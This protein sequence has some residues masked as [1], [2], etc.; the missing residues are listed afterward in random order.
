MAS[1]RRAPRTGASETRKKRPTGGRSRAQKR[2]P[3]ALKHAEAQAGA[4]ADAL[5]RL[6]A[7]LRQ[8][9]L[10]D[11]M[12]DGSRK[13]LAAVEIIDAVVHGLEAN[14]DSELL[15]LRKAAIA[16]RRQRSDEVWDLF[17]LFTTCAASELIQGLLRERRYDDAG[18]H[19]ARHLEE[20]IIGLADF[21][22]NLR[23][24]LPQVDSLHASRPEL[25][26]VLSAR[27]EEDDRDFVWAEATLRAAFRVWR[28]PT[29]EAENMTAFIWKRLQKEAGE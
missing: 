23:H 11:V 1:A 14:D 20:A 2:S 24:Q 22:E 18:E 26:R 29:K 19:I 4:V 27:L 17:D 8:R 7:E 16:S 25:A 13:A 15:A 9:A 5:K 3:I 10:M 12:T 21:F 6:R 28:I